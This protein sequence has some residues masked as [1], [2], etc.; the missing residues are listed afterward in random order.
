MKTSRN[1]L[2]LVLIANTMTSCLFGTSSSEQESD[3]GYENEMAFNNQ[4]GFEQSLNTQTNISYQE[5]SNN[6]RNSE[7][8]SFTNQ[9]NGGTKSFGLVDP[10]TGQ[11]FGSMPIPASWQPSRNSKETYLEGPGEVKVY[12]DMSNFFHYSNNATYNQII[13]QNGNQLKRTMT[14]EQ[15]FNNE[16]LPM[17]Q[18]EGAKLVRKTALPVFAQRERQVDAMFFK[19]MPE[20]T[21]FEAMLTE[22]IDRRR[23]TRIDCHQT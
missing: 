9:N 13:Q 21:Q 5:R 10:S 14:M 3:F 20:Q 8:Q 1:I 15:F 23:K 12:N 16:F 17:A 11:T 19:G 6:T 4:A 2:I 22:W 7:N 18:K